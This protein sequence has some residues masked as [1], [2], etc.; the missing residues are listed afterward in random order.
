MSSPSRGR[1]IKIENGYCSAAIPPN[2]FETD[3]RKV[4]KRQMVLKTGFAGCDG[5]FWN[6]N[7]VSQCAKVCF[8]TKTWFRNVRRVFWN[9]KAVKRAS[10]APN[11][12]KKWLKRVFSAILFKT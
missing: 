7:K 11:E 8:E 1:P 10:Q 9:Q 4:R 3:R 6:E 2:G 5:A 12:N